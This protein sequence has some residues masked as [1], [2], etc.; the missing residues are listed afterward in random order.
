MDFPMPVASTWLCL[1]WNDRTCPAAPPN[2]TFFRGPGKSPFPQWKIRKDR[3]IKEN[4]GKYGKIWENMGKIWE[5]IGKSLKFSTFFIH[6]QWT[7][8]GY[9]T[10]GS[11]PQMFLTLTSYP[12][13]SKG[14]NGQFPLY[15]VRDFS[16]YSPPFFMGMSQLTTVER[17]TMVM[18]PHK[19]R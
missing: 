2:L 12:P 7:F 6:F 4:R 19:L 18:N 5:N 14:G 16:S 10:H 3:T 11:M 13:A 8:C 1:A 17:I 15:D 9:C